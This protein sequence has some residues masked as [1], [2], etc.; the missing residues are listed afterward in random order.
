MKLGMIAL[1]MT[2]AAV[3]AAADRPAGKKPKPAPA[4]P[5]K[6]QETVIPEGAVEIRP[7]TYSYTDPKGQ[8]WLYS[9]TPF[10]VM[11]TEVKPESAEDAKKAQEARARLIEATSAVEVG[12]SIR[13]ERASPFGPM[14]WQQKK[15]ALNEIERAVWDRELAKHTATESATQAGKD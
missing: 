5:A 4:A 9:K 11:R 10:G 2:C 3:A 7:Y 15:T 12:D 14:H 8:K 6:V 1:L 13:F